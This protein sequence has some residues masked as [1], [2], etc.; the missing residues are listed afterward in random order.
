M[1]PCVGMVPALADRRCLAASEPATASTGT[2]TPK[3]PNHM[4]IA[5]ITL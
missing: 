2:I 3:R 1:G 5:S 4:A